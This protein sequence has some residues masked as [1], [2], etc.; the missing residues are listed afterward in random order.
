MRSHSM[1]ESSS[2]API[3]IKPIKNFGHSRRS[4]LN[5]KALQL[6][7]HARRSKSIADIPANDCELEDVRGQPVKFASQLNKY[8]PKVAVMESEQE[9]SKESKA[10]ESPNKAAAVH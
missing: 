3:V 1:V 8:L 5:Q 4:N 2:H 6:Q 9:E 7:R 10:I